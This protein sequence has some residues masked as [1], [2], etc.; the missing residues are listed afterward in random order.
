M[1]TTDDVRIDSL[2]PLIPPAILMEELP[3]GDAG[4]KLISEARQEVARIVTGEDDRVVVV[5]GPCSIHDP[6]AGLEYAR[7]LK[8][9]AAALSADLKIV[10]RT[11][12]EKPRTTVGWKGLINDPKLDGSF[13][14]N[15]GLRVAR[16]FLLDVVEL[17]MPTGTEF[18]D[19]ISPQFM[20]DLV[21]WG[22]IGARTTESQV[23]REL[24]SGL[25]MP[26]GFKNG[27]S[28][29]VQIAVDAVR[30]SAEPH[31]FLSVTKQG[32]AAIVATRGNKHCHVIL[33]GGRSGPNYSEASVT[34][35]A[36]ALGKA[37]LRQA[38]MVDC[39]HAN[40]QKDHKNQVKVAES[41]AAQISAGSTRVFGV[42]VESNLV[43]GRQ[44]VTPGQPLT[45][46][47]SITDACLGFEQTRP[48]LE[49][50][51][52]AVRARRKV[53]G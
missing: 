33:R 15:Q 47:Q 21:A 18:L 19:P 49:L 24:A 5:V 27:T 42:M 46:G 34:E 40:S 43:E 2:R 16:K 31:R 28:G 39:S 41:L 3:V 14:I 48:L 35:A 9:V 50:L 17:G 32:L 30:S 23:H 45:R 10:M 51:A 52:S 8:P 44:D 4:T 38:V 7:Q 12:F 29:N 26:V 11:Y 25:S 13:S 53:Q 6:D 1:P 20:A 36:D 37:N 22:A